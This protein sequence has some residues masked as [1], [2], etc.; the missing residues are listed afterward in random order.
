MGGL[1]Y[2]VRRDMRHDFWDIKKVL[3]R[4]AWM[5]G[6]GLLM[7]GLLACSL[8]PLVPGLAA[9]PSPVPI[10]GPDELRFK[11]PE[12]GR[13]FKELNTVIDSFVDKSWMT[14]PYHL[15]GNFYE[16][17]WCSGAGADCQRT[18]A[19]FGRRDQRLLEL[20]T[21]F[22]D[23][24]FPEV[25][26]LGFQAVWVPRT[27]GWGASFG[28]S[29]GG[30][31]VVADGWGVTF[32]QYLSPAGAPDA[33]LSLGQGDS[34]KIY[35]TTIRYISG[36]SVRDDLAPYLA[37]P[38]AMREQGVKKLGAFAEQVRSEIG[39]DQVLA[40]DLEPYK[41]NGIPPVCKPRPMT[42]AEKVS[43]L[44]RAEADFAAREQLLSDH[45]QEMYAAWMQA[46]PVERFWGPATIHQ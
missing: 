5:V 33:T 39:T 17:A 34:Y 42:A 19:I 6:L 13:R 43:E 22:Y 3:V 28:F 9:T 26:G 44:A 24:D 16:A 30:E 10:P 8:F 1:L 35:E 40:C 14:I 21:L 25:F 15:S 41:G 2:I 38:E 20:Y 31:R 27:T 36:K 32:N 11:D 29:E 37:G 45:Y 4:R 18:D 12:T 23:A 46:F 7:M